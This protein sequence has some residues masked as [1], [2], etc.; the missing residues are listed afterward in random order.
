MM[1]L[2]RRILDQ[3]PKLASCSVAHYTKGLLPQGRQ[4]PSILIKPKLPAIPHAYRMAWNVLPPQ[5]LHRKTS[6][7]IFQ[8]LL[9]YHFLGN[10]F[11]ALSGRIN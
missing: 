10:V 1:P 7:L 3:Y 6:N 2:E 4:V 8:A 5:L 11:L 9:K